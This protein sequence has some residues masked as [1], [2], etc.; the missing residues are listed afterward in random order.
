MVTG[1]SRM[2]TGQPTY[3]GNRPSMRAA[4]GIPNAARIEGRFPQYVGCPVVIL[5][6][7]V[8]IDGNRRSW[9][10][11]TVRRTGRDTGGHHCEVY[12]TS[13]DTVKHAG[14]WVASSAE[15]IEQTVW[16]VTDG[17]WHVDVTLG[18]GVSYDSAALIVQAVR[19]RTLVNQIPAVL[20][21]MF[22]DTLPVVDA[23]DIQTIAKSRRSPGY[24]VT[25]GH[26]G[27]LVLYVSFDAG[28]VL[29]HN[30]GSWR[31]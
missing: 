9:L 27:G 30:I 4:F 6:S 23:S 24:E 13:D 1:D 31:S 18:T 22:G 26:A 21:R 7:P 5:E 19:H 10:E 2:T 12:A 3:C 20:R 16:R 11:L 8:T 25:T 15:R 14:R 28:Q 17:D 29:V